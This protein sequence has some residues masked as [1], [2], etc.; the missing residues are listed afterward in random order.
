[1]ADQSGAILEDRFLGSLLGLA[2][3]DA[4]GASFEGL[5]AAYMSENFRTGRELIAAVSL[6]DL[7]YTDDTQ[8]T[9]GVAETLV[10]H[11]RIDTPHLCKCFAKNFDPN[12]G[13]G[14]GA[15]AVLYAM[16]KGHDHRYLAEN[17]FPGGSYGN[18]GAMRV[19]PVGL[20]FRQNHEQ[21]W[22]QAKLSA[23]PT[24]VHPLGIEGAQVLALAI[25]IAS[26]MK[27]YSKQ[28]FF[29][30]L[31]ARC[32]S[33]A[34]RGPLRRAKD[35]DDIKDLGLFGNGIEAP[36]SVVTA[37]ATFGLTPNCYEST[38]TNAV[39]LG[40]DTDTIA[41]MAGAIS[42]AYLGVDAIPTQL[43]EG[44]EDGYQ[45]RAYISRLAKE[46]CTA[47]CNLNR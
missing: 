40:G 36:E 43:I 15:R 47:H 21:L 22:E 17:Y 9:I 11:G 46:L 5:S 12:R 18:G 1:M 4:V 26:E 7:C 13:Y 38:I 3:G 39:F 34:Y 44:L 6:G 28:E 2:V 23:L 19:A 45:G 31:I 33:H 30:Q 25:G 27:E 37:I 41:A 20:F 14:G 29:Q 10:R 16:K 32:H 35:L 8:M 42:G 24:H